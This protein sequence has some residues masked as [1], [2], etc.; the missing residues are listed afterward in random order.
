MSFKMELGKVNIL[1]INKPI[2][3]SFAHNGSN[4]KSVLNN[5]TIEMYEAVNSGVAVPELFIG[6]I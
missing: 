5:W 4:A 3:A 6:G 1:Q 2:I